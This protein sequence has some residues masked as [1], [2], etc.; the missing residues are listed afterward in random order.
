MHEKLARCAELCLD[1][2][3]ERLQAALASSFKN[4]QREDLPMKM[5]RD[6]ALELVRKVAQNL[7][8]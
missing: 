7:P 1:L 3:S 8:R 4:G 6:V 5:K 2:L